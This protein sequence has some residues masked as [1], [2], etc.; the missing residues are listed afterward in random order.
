[1]AASE[2]RDRARLALDQQLAAANQLA[3]KLT[4]PRGGWLRAIRDALGVPSAVLARRLGLNQSSV[5]RLEQNESDGVIQLDT[6][7]RVADALGCELVYALIPRRSLDETLR[8]RAREI[9]LAELRSVEHTMA[10]EDQGTGVD[11]SGLE[12]LTEDLLRNG[13][14]T[15]D[16]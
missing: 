4:V 1:M 7:R 14:V 6:L 11:P 5:I 12:R 13:Q 10:L 16:E 9:A 3:P 8:G 15:W 2:R